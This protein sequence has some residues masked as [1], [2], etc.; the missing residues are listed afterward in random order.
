MTNSQAGHA[1]NAESKELEKQTVAS[2]TPSF[3]PVVPL[4]PG[5]TILDRYQ[6]VELLGRG[7]MGSVYHVRHL[8]LQTDFA[9][10]VLDAQANESNWRRFENE[11]RAAS[12]LD[13]P[14]LI[15]VHDSGLLD[16]GQPFFIMELVRGNT[17]ADVLKKKGRL[18]LSQVLNFSI[19]VGFALAYAHDT[20]VIH[21]DLKPSN[22]M[23]V[24][25]SAGSLF[26]SVKVV[27]LG[28]A[29]L[30]GADE[31]NQ[32]TLT[33]TG[34]I[35]G[36]PLYMSPEQCMGTA[37][38][39][40][41][42]LYSLGCVMYEALTGAPPLIGDN[43]LST[44]M[45]HQSEKPLSLKEA[46]LGITFPQA[47]EDL[48]ATLLEKDPGKR[49]QNAHLLT[50]ALVGIQQSL[51][52]IF[53]TSESIFSK[54]TF[55]QQKRKEGLPGALNPLS[56]LLIFSAFGL[57]YVCGNWKQIQTEPGVKPRESPASDRMNK[58]AN[59]ILV[60]AVDIS[61]NISQQGD[62]Y[63]GTGPDYFSKPIGK[64][65]VLWNFPGEH[66]I[67][68]IGFRVGDRSDDFKYAALGKFE[69]PPGKIAF[70]ADP[71]IYLYPKLFQKFRPDEL[72]SLT[73]KGAQRDAG[74]MLQALSPQKNLIY[75]YLSGTYVTREDLKQIGGLPS[76]RQ[77]FLGG[78]HTNIHTLEML[79]NLLNLTDL[80]VSGTPNISSLLHKLTESKLLSVLHIR[81]CNI[82][83]DDLK[84]VSRLH[85]LTDL[86]LSGNT[87]VND[88]NIAYLLNLKKLRSIKLENCRITKGC[89]ETLKKFSDI[90]ISI[91]KGDFSEH[92][93][94]YLKALLPNAKLKL[95][96]NDNDAYQFLDESMSTP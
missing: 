72:V 76:L 93:F 19:Q 88:K 31:Y 57:G 32:Q 3:K 44:M 30:T 89:V 73:L 47:A 28:I 67:G 95:S 53:E 39:K 13:H 70:R 18:S 25:N 59:S 69:L 40:R 33:K 27:D 82:T 37:V 66:K 20:G 84:V 38:D 48:V 16:D 94:A 58:D 86:D 10:K 11:A 24:E 23:L 51:Q 1:A 36:S 90:H 49:Y 62:H 75:L 7:G 15:K 8:H 78:S 61:E 85:N 74:P 54:P 71:R 46:S 63:L 64:N 22:I 21:R 6:V 60:K 81:E 26:S 12:R 17:L 87:A 91:S 29:K 65:R 14:N 79:P 96:D 34:E 77:L 80:D 35:F 41:A 83:D 56:M 92:D 4:E 42:D 68:D 2:G 5:T 52:D 9:L 45:K 50:A 43:A 55:A